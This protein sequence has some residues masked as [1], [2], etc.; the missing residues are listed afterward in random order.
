MFTEFEFVSIMTT[1]TGETSIKSQIEVMF[2]YELKLYSLVLKSFLN[3]ELISLFSVTNK[4]Y[5]IT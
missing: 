4:I 5:P 3:R 2:E 1:S